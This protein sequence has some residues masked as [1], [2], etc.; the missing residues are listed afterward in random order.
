MEGTTA[1]LVSGGPSALKE[2]HRLGAFFGRSSRDRERAA[3][4]ASARVISEAITS[5]S[6]SPRAEG[7]EDSKSG[8]SGAI[9]RLRPT[10]VR[11]EKGPDGAICADKQEAN[12]THS[13][14]LTATIAW[15]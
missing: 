8:R 3:L 12:R 15:L 1:T 5:V 2:G 9:L 14:T 11:D 4:P 13:D 7:K 6:I 10:N